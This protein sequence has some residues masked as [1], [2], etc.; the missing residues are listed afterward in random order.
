MDSVMGRDY[1]TFFAICKALG[2][3]KE[4]VVYEFTG[5]ETKSLSALNDG[6]WKELMIQ[7]RKRQPARQP[8]TI[9]PG[10]AQRKK[11]SAIAGKMQWGNDTIE[12]VG[13]LNVWCQ[14][15]YGEEFNELDIPTLN[16][17]VWVLEN[18]IQPDYL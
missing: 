2:L 15:Q 12:I 17:A 6:E 4:E 10:D 11:M 3:D 1:R 14:E 8:L 18:K 13:K 7:L 5:G 16:K 9:R